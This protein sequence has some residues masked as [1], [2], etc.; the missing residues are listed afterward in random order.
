MEFGS[1]SDDVLQSYKNKLQKH[2]FPQDLRAKPRASTIRKILSDFKKV[3]VFETD[4]IDLLLMRVE[5]AVEFNSQHFVHQAVFY[6]STISSYQE[7]LEYI[8]RCDYQELF[9][10]RCFAIAKQAHYLNHFENTLLEKFKYYF[11]ES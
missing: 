2:F 3:A 5:L 10:E 9:Q 6:K 11:D 8:V 1:S 4:Y 7:A